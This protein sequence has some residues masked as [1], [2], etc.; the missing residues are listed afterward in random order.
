MSDVANEAMMVLF[1]FNFIFADMV[2]IVKK[3]NQIIRYGI[4]GSRFIELVTLFDDKNPFIK[5]E[6]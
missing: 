2:Y 4:N 3:R 5:A 1:L 6:R